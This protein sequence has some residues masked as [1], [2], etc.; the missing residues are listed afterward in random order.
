MSYRLIRPSIF[1]CALAALTGCE[2]QVD[3]FADAPDATPGD[4][5]C[6]TLAGTCTLRA[7]IE[8]ANANSGIWTI[9]VPAGNYELDLPVRSGGGS[10][11]ITSS[12]KIQGS[13]AGTTIIE[14]Q[15]RDT[16]FQ[17]EIG[18]VEINNVTI[19]GGDAQG[20]G[21]IYQNGGTV[22]LA[23]SVIRD[24]AATTGG[25]GIYI[26]EGAEMFIRRSTITEN[27]A[28]G[29]FGGG[30]WNQGTLWVYESAVIDNESN[31]AGGIRNS[32]NMN[33]R[34]TTVSGNT[35]SSPDAGVGGISQIGFAVLNNVTITDNTGVGNS[36]GSF[37]GGGLQMSGSATT[38][39]KNSIV[40][41]N[42]GNGG[43]ADCVGT[44]SFDS[45]Y[46]LIGDDTD[47]NIPGFVFTYLLNVDPA[48][49]PLGNN[50][51]P[52]RTH[53]TTV[54]SPARQAA[55]EFPPPAADACELYDQRGVP[56]PQG[57][58]QGARCDMGAYES[59]SS[60]AFVTGLILVDA[61]SDT[62][63]GPLLY[64]ARLDLSELPDNLSVRAAV[65]GTTGSVTF[66][67][68]DEQDF[69]TEN[70]APYALNGDNMGNY[71]PLVIEPG[72]HVIVATPYLQ[73]D[74]V[75]GGSAAG[76]SLTIPIVVVE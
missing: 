56:R 18:E 28:I 59:T 14:Q 67:Y 6:A 29:A 22:N 71:V 4:R 41:G 25:A 61:D 36:L 12:M 19:A 65:S 7:A 60:G 9:S 57:S 51:G 37:R 49:T 21:G 38:V 30:I 72:D 68:D 39:M 24:N 42:N 52:T 50:G 73:D 34:S 76:G 64:G 75:E 15:E 40:A 53:A 58:G 45:K 11:D 66:D 26:R 8:E 70:V 23:Y 31:R 74:G 17:I 69:R 13:G 55:Y 63:I 1:L 16:V 3:S 46:N 33:L 2:Y 47:C 10:L 32:G 5:E 62:D 48:L 54:S 27:D 35:T 20:G 44:L 43:P